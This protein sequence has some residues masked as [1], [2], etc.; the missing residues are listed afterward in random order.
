MLLAIKELYGVDYP[1]L[2]A[3]YGASRGR[4]TGSS[5]DNAILIDGEERLNTQPSQESKARASEQGGRT[6]TDSTSSRSC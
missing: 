6:M 1:G 3:N 4:A 5:V 2:V